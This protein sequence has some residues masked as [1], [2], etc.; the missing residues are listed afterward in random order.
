MD[1]EC[2][3]IDFGMND[4]AIRNLRV[5]KDEQVSL[6]IP[7]EGYLG[8]QLRRASVAMQKHLSSLYK[9]LG[10]KVIEGSVLLM[11]EA[12]P[13]IKQSQIGKTFDIKSAN[14]VPLVGFLEKNDCIERKPIDGRSHGLFLDGLWQK[15]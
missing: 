4:L 13:G 15:L 11:I 10:F 6:N 8:Y 12:N 2:K 7:L 9:K 5:R 3:G 1:I 14:L